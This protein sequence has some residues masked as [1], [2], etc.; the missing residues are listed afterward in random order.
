[1]GT[2]GVGPFEN[3]SAADFVR[4]LDNTPEAG[5]LDMIKRV[6]RASAEP[7]EGFLDQDEAVVAIAAAAIIAAYMP[8]GA[9]L[10]PEFDPGPLIDEAGEFAA[11]DLAS[12]ALHSLE[13]VVAGDSEL[14]ALWAETEKHEDW[15]TSIKLLRRSLGE[16]PDV[17]RNG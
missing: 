15:R 7:S 3:D 2:W 11:A 12:L 6:L 16:T 17:A 5:R 14:D 4:D 9:P 8:G 1:M 13:R 10:D